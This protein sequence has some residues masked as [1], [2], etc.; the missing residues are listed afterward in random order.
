MPRFST[1]WWNVSSRVE[2]DL[3]RTSNDLEGFHNGLGH[4]IKVDH[5][6]V[7]I[8]IKQ[9]KQETVF[10]LTA[11]ANSQLPSAS[12]VTAKDKRANYYALTN[13]Q[14]QNALKDLDDGNLGIMEFLRQIA[15]R[16][17]LAF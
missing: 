13:K 2:S 7:W 17:S 1:E 15:H 12:D 10:T 6:N 9:L 16:V 14:I 8:L 4:S 3:P 5:P 11:L